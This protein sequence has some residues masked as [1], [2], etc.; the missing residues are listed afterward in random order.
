MG[1]HRRLIE[2]ARPGDATRQAEGI[3]LRAQRA[4]E[5]PVAHHG[6]PDGGAHA[7]DGLEERRVALLRLK[8]PHGEEADRIRRV[9]TV[10]H[11]AER[12]RRG[13]EPPVEPVVDELDPAGCERAQA[14]VAGRR[15]GHGEPR[16]GELL[17]ELPIRRRPDVLRVPGRAVPEP[18][19]RRRVAR[20]GRGRVEEVRVEVRG[21]GRELG[22][23]DAGLAEAAPSVRRRIAADVAEPQPERPAVA[24]GRAPERPRVAGQH[25]ARAPR[26][27]TREDRSRP[28]GRSHGPGA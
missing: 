5:R 1:A 28:R 11:R 26:G 3:D 27:D 24:P 4:L 7:R 9:P 19:H 17:A 20:D 21:L 22:R 8:A 2:G 16:L 14:G 10:A 15:A 13:E 25:A 12:G 23:E 18:A 6:E